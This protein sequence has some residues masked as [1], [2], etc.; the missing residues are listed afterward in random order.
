[1]PA[2]TRNSLVRSLKRN[3]LLLFVLMC[4]PAEEFK[5]AFDINFIGVQNVTSSFLPLLRKGTKKVIVEI[6]TFLASIQL[7][8]GRW[9]MYAIHA[10]NVSKAAVNF[11]VRTYAAELADEG[12]TVIA[13]NPGVCLLRFLMRLTKVCEY[14]YEPSG[15]FKYKRICKWDCQS[16]FWSC[17]WEWGILSGAFSCGDQTDRQW[18]GSKHPW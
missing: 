7:N 2:S 10:Y 8:D 4:S 9:K 13:L 1:M 12:F 5:H 16:V 3:Y 18:D 6:S 14:G 11:L 15:H 17:Y